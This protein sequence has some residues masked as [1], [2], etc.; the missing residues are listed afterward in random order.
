MP[1]ISLYLDDDTTRRM[2]RAAKA[3]GLSQSR[4][5][6]RLVREKTASEWPQSLVRLAGAWADFPA[7]EE[8]RRS[9]GTDVPREPL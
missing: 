3:A 2:K 6:A 4:W 1:Q 9:L 7:A 5:V 8:L